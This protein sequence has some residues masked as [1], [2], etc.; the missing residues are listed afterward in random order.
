MLKAIQLGL[1]SDP[2]S[3]QLYYQM[4]IEAKTNLPV[5]QCARGTNNTEGSVH[6]SLRDQMPKSGTSIRHAAARIRD[7]VFIHNLV[8]GTLNRSGKMYQGHYNVEVLNRL[9]LSLE[10][11]RGLV[12]NAPILRGWINGDLYIQGNERIGILPIPKTTRTNA[13]IL[14]HHG[15]TD[16]EYKHHFLAAQ[17]GTK[18]AVIAVHSNEEKTLSSKMIQESPC[19]NIPSQLPDFKE[20]ARE[21]NSKLNG[22][23]IF[24]KVHLFQLDFYVILTGFYSL[25][26]I[27]SHIIES[28][29][30]MRMKRIHLLRSCLKQSNC[31]KNCVVMSVSQKPTLY[32]LSHFK[33]MLPLSL[34]I[35]QQVKLCLFLLLQ[36]N[37]KVIP[38]SVSLK[39][40]YGK[41]SVKILAGTVTN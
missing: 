41:T 33:Q 39:G 19:F 6:K 27:F 2:P 35:W 9:Q 11:A 16:S 3:V 32:L 13:G 18:Y 25:K 12:P 30:V 1:L 8:V 36:S 21:W 7:Y 23:T 40:V 34:D 10:A 24:Y 20:G 31:N 5:Y 14:R 15:S 22:Q 26:L 4:Y 38:H 17:Q 37:R 29:C 28:G